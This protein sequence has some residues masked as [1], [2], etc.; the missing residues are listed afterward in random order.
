MA[1]LIATPPE[2]YSGVLLALWVQQEELWAKIRATEAR[3]ARTEADLGPLTEMLMR[4][5]EMLA[6]L[7]N[8]YT[9]IISMK[10]F[11]KIKKDVQS[12]RKVHRDTVDFIRLDTE[13]AKAMQDQIV[14]LEEQ[15]ESL[16]HPDNLLTFRP[17]S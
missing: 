5:E 13:A 11:A 8:D 7:K 9:V 15:I 6:N 2:G 4:H 1:G 3:L 17:K 10:E 14:K 12:L 16:K